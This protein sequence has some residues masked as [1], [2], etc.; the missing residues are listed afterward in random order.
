MFERFFGKKKTK[1]DE[2]AEDADAF[3][4]AKQDALDRTLGTMDDMV[5]HAIIPFA[6]GGGLDLYPFSKCIPGTVIATQELIGPGKKERPKKGKA[7]YFER[8]A[9]LPPGKTMDDKPA[10]QLINSMLNPIARYSFMASLN[11]GETAELP[12]EE[13]QP[14]LPVCFDAFKGKAPFEVKGEKFHLLLC[15]ALHQSELDYARENTT[16][17]LLEKLKQAGVYPYSYLDRK[18]VV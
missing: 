17:D 1:E 5:M 15:I 11:P 14:N 16:E 2:A 6:I 13:D 3:A 8:V 7:G 4:Q 18:P 12:T 9:C 10:L